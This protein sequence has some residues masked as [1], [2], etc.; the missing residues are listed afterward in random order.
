M[1]PRT[2]DVR[3]DSLLARKRGSF[4]RLLGIALA[5]FVGRVLAVRRRHVLTALAHAQIADG[6]RVADGM[7]R[8]LARGLFELL[9]LGLRTPKS[10]GERV[11]I[12]DDVRALLEPGRGLVVATAHTG[13]WDLLACA[14]AQ[15]IPLT[16]VTKRLSVS[17]L[18][19]FWQRTRARYGV[20]WVSVGRVVETAQ[21]AL[22]RGE[23]VAM[24]IDQAPERVRARVVVT[25]L[26]QVAEVDLAPALVAMRARVPL[27]LVVA[28]RLAGGEQRARLLA[29][30]EPPARPSRRWAEETMLQAT[31]A[32]E[33]H[34]RRCPEQWLWMHRRWKRS[35]P[36][37]LAAAN[38]AVRA[39]PRV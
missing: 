24:L 9:A 22:G 5:F 12:P 3:P 33:G 39:A 27:A 23:A 25:F 10:L 21:A 34:I 36:P 19:R 17:F 2:P 1:R 8:S 15:R 30:F 18:D 26:N 6:A 35:V 29:H 11:H 4:A 14:A 32:L 31:R 38:P 16:V 13:N 28:E 37:A 7:Y 20:R